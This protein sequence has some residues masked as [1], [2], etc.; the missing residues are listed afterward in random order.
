MSK[1]G[2]RDEWAFEQGL[3]IFCPPSVRDAIT[4][5]ITTGVSKHGEHPKPF[6]VIPSQPVGTL[7][8]VWKAG[9]TWTTGP[10]ASYAAVAM[11][12]AEAVDE[13]QDVHQAAELVYAEIMKPGVGRIH[14]P[15]TD[16]ALLTMSL[17]PHRNAL[18]LRN[19]YNT[20][21]LHHTISPSALA[22]KIQALHGD[23][24]RQDDAAAGDARFLMSVLCAPDLPPASAP[25]AGGGGDAM[26]LDRPEEEGGEQH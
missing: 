1:R 26:P 11:P 19:L 15:A 7:T 22:N 5:A 16:G 2:R 18:S 17:T 25:A 9:K 6:T 4:S 13:V 12:A 3:R 21:K 20:L 24:T 8:I 23:V 10:A 14:L